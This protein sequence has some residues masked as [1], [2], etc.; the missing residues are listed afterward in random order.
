VQYGDAIKVL[1]SLPLFCKLDPSRLKLLA[2]SSTYLTFEKGE[3]LFHEGEA[4]DGAYVIDEG[5]V[6]VLIA[7]EGR[8]IKV[9]VLGRHD[10]FGEMAIILNQPRTATIRAAQPLKVLKIDAGVF[11]RLVTENP[12]AALAVMRSLSDKIARATERYQE[13]ESRMHAL[14]MTRERNPSPR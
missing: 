11:L 2:F 7:K 12:D 6:D 4:P 14:Q 5:E 3:D 1:R 9:G 13:L 8:Q 10:L